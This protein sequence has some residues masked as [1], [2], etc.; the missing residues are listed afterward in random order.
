PGLSRFTVIESA[1]EECRCRNTFRTQARILGLPGRRTS[2][3][4]SP[5]PGKVPT[6]NEPSDTAA[7]REFL[8][9]VKVRLVAPGRAWTSSHEDHA[10]ECQAWAGRGTAWVSSAGAAEKGRRGWARLR[11]D[12]SSPPPGRTAPPWRRADWGKESPP[13][14]GRRPK[15]VCPP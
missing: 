5:G 9:R 7:G 3:M 10:V 14:R 11:R 1:C 8:D 12:G 2:F 6:G 13:P 15:R 4:D